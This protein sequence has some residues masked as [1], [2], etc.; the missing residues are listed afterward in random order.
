M[1]STTMAFILR[2]PEED[3]DGVACRLSCG[4]GEYPEAR[5]ANRDWIV[6][7]MDHGLKDSVRLAVRE[8]FVKDDPRVNAEIAAWV[9][10]LPTDAKWREFHR[11]LSDEWWSHDPAAATKGL[12]SL[13]PGDFRDELVAARASTILLNPEHYPQSQLESLLPLLNSP[14]QRER[15]ANWKW[16]EPHGDPSPADPDLDPFADPFA[17]SEP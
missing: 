8:L 9:P 15:F 14:Q 2:L 11:G 6:K 12:A 3:R 7:L 17:P 13:P 4:P 5:A 10:T 16:G 1:D